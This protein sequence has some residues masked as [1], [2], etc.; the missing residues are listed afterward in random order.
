MSVPPPP[1]E[2]LLKQALEWFFLLQS[3]SCTDENRQQFNRWYYK[4][5]ANQA[6]YAHAELL[7]SDLNQL[8]KAIDIPGLE[9][10]RQPRSKRRL[11]RARG[12]AALMLVSSGL[13]SLG[14]MEYH[15]E[16]VTYSTQLG[17]QQTITL[18]DGSTIDLNTA[19]RLHARI[20]PLQRNIIL[21]TGEAIFDVQHERVRSF[22]VR[23]EALFIRDIGTRF[24]VR[25]QN[26]VVSVA[27][28]QGAVEI[29]G[30]RMDEGYQRWYQPGVGLS[31]LQ[32]IDAT[33]IEA[34]TQGR[35][36]FRQAPVKEVVSELERYHSVH[37]VFAEP[38]IANATL[39]GTF[40]TDDLDLFLNSLEKILPVKISRLSDEQT[41]L[42]D[43]AE[44]E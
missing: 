21:D 9:E 42:I 18:S 4:S 29:N 35:L 30:E 43:W 19:T 34:W 17:E 28:L 25:L 1:N 33:E 10:A 24:N 14:W 12:I 44:K 41:L 32:P 26:D 36:I 37:F 11:V 8:K 2:R 6:A 38:S 13:I 39:S 3:E 16:T 20:S 27:V 15:A 23:T 31:S 5:E 22:N 40:D 7:W